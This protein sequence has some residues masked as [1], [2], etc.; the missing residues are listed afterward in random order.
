MS[1]NDYLKIKLQLL[2]FETDVQQASLA[3]A[4]ALSHL[5]QQLG[6]E[7]VPVDYDIAGEFE[8]RP[9]AVTLEELQSK[10]LENRPDL[11]AAVLGVTAA[12]S[13]YALAKANGK[14]DP[15]LSLI[16]RTSTASVPPP[17]RLVFRWQYLTATK[18]ILRR[19]VWPSAK[20]KSSGRQP[21][22]KY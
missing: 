2:Q 8:F 14:Q 12:T 22:G 20:R 15:T 4:Q 7:S 19:R 5:R 16:T 21:T 10:A 3:R 9:M 11:R 18:A 6:Y 13:Q 1:E 17:G